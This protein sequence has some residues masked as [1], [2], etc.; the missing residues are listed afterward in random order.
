V[1]CYVC[2]VLLFLTLNRAAYQGYFQADELDTM[3]WAP[4]VGCIE[5]LKAVLS[6]QF[7]QNNFRPVGHFLFYAGGRLFGFDFAKWAGLAQGIHLL[8]VMLLWLV[9][10]RLGGSP[11]AAAAGC[12]FW[13][14]HM[15]LFDAF[16]KPMYIFDVVCAT[17]SL[18]AILLY[19]SERWIA[20]F[21][22]FWL[23]YKAKELA[24]M[25]PLAL[26]ASEYYFGTG[27]W[28]RRLIRLAPFFLA[29]LSFGLQAVFTSPH[30]ND[31]YTFRFT[32]DALKNTGFY[33]A[34]R[35]F[36]VPYLGFSVV[37]AGIVWRRKLIR[38]GLLFMLLFFLPL[39]FLPGR[40][41]SAYCYA[42]FLGLAIL[43]AGIAETAPPAALAL[44][45]LI[46]APLDLKALRRQS[47]ATLALDADIREWV[48]SVR[49]A[50]DFAPAPQ[51]V[52]YEGQIPGFDEWGERGAIRC[53]FG[54]AGAAVYSAKDPGVS[55]AMD[56]PRTLILSW[57]NE[58]HRL[59]MR[60]VR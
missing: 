29:S 15:A 32:L 36:L 55:A 30:H 3:S 57:K 11:A 13:G 34:G 18:S 4:Q 8:N 2:F 43:V 53:V 22:C 35:I 10:R 17:F 1:L 14:L 54:D 37:L 16:W 59:E 19:R 23:A 50:A 40:I 7:Q 56:S 41:F 38:V 48:S 5:Y 60:Y 44:A 51:T 33:Y 21:V 20:S 31:A 27:P 28:K 26:L 46:W 49:R 39:V 25:L 6:P 58:S 42:P 47:R 24:V 52:I 9:I 12:L 45:L